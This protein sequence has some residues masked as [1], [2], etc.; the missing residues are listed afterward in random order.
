MP[1]RRHDLLAFIAKRDGAALLRLSLHYISSHALL[2]DPKALA[3]RVLGTLSVVLDKPEPFGALV[4]AV[5]V[6]ICDEFE[7][8][9]RLGRAA[10]AIP[11][12]TTIL[13]SEEARVVHRAFHHIPRD[14]RRSL[15]QVAI[16][17]I[18]EGESARQQ[19]ITVGELRE[20]V[21]RA[22]QQIEAAVYD[23]ATQTHPTG[24]VQLEEMSPGG[25]PGPSEKY[26][27]ETEHP[28]AKFPRGK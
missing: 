17:G 27:F 21:S 26:Q 13:G 4:H 8:D 24:A 23:A 20:R 7:S 1:S 9:S 3:L 5:F 10:S 16:L 18:E 12:D 2:A 15:H 25:D 14:D 6:R 11:G 22:L 19:N 28:V